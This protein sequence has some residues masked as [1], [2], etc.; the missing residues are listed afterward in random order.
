M[1]I[2]EVKL[3]LKKLNVK[4]N[5]NLGQNFIVNNHTVQKIISTSDISKD[6]IIVE[7]GPGLGVL[8]ESLVEKAK[9]VYAIEIDPS[10]SR[11]LS[12]KFSVYENLEV[13]NEDILE[14]DIPRHNKVVANIPYSI[15]GSIFEKVFFNQTPPH[16]IM[17]IER[18]IANRIFISGN[19]KDFSRISVSVNAYLIPEMRFPISR[20]SFYP[21]PNINLSLIKVIPREKLNDFLLDQ[22]SSVFFLKLVAGIMPYKNKDLINALFLFF[23]A[24]NNYFLTKDRITSVL[25]EK[26]YI[27]KKVFTLQIDE[28]IE[29]SNLFYSEK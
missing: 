20:S 26:S 29:L 18:N 7:I 12:E 21:I 10:L 5:K 28:F 24:S 2:K 9:M 16:G 22:E 3:I 8:T 6:D 1:N 17:T 15:T 4:P 23:K 14:T 19:Y 25:R 13:I 27:D 11:Y